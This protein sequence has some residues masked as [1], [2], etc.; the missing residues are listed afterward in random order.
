M[1]C[2]Y[3]CCNNA[4]VYLN[5]SN[6]LEST[7]ERGGHCPGSIQCLIPSWDRKCSRV[8]MLSMSPYITALLHHTQV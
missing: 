3:S 6:T 4:T 5:K 2:F 7:A 1:V 8:E